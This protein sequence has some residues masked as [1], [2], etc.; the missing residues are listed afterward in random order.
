MAENIVMK[1]VVYLLIAALMFASSCKKRDALVGCKV[2]SINVSLADK[3]VSVSISNPEGED[4]YEVEYGSAGF[5]KGTGT[6]VSLSGGS[7]TINFT[8]Y[9]VYDF[10][11]RSKCGNTY[12]EW[13][14]R[15]TASVDGGYSSCG[16]PGGLDVNTTTYS[17]YELRWNGSGNFY[18]VEYGPTGFTIGNGTRIRTNDKYTRDQIMQSGV[19]YDFYV[20]A[21]CGGNTFSSWAGPRS[22]YSDR[23][24]NITVPCTPPSSL[25]AYRTSSN[26]IS[27]TA[28]GNGTLSYEVSISTSNTSLTSNIL[29]YSSPNGALYNTGGYSGTRYCWM[30]GKCF[31]G[32]F[33]NWSVV[34]VN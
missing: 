25:Y 33:T 27:F 20:R 4:G 24:Q 10:Y 2:P 23:N 26:E 19:T 21:N 16:K 5:S 7:T 30:R 31:N 29:S 32:S 14:G 6:V 1:N 13:S 18:D 3:N 22:L 12:S 9:G 11:A 17:V 28:Q 34:L 8:D 15:S